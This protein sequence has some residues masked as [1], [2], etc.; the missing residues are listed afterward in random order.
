MSAGR[1]DQAAA[2]REVADPEHPRHRRPGRGILRRTRGAVC[3][4]TEMPRAGSSRAEVRP[5][6]SRATALTWA[7]SR[8]MRRW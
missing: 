8:E 6:N 7:V 1:V 5:A 3:R 2:Q 4:E